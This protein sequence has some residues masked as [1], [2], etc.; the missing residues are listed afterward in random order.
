MTSKSKYQ[1]RFFLT[2]EGTRQAAESWNVIGVRPGLQKLIREGASICL[3]STPPS[4][5]FLKTKFNLSTS[6]IEYNQ[7][8][9]QKLLLESLIKPYP[10]PLHVSK[11][12]VLK[13]KEGNLRVCLDLAELGRHVANS[14]FRMKGVIE[15]R[16]HMRRGTYRA[17]LDLKDAYHS[18]SMS[19]RAW[20]L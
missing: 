1:D 7:A 10:Y 13:Q 20:R 4:C 16:V 18:I 19:R 2:L 17:K 3:T 11:L 9:L 5:I 15:A 12:L 14:T 8:Y 6:D